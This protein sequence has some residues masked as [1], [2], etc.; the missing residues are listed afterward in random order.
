MRPTGTPH[1]LT[2]PQ[3][4]SWQSWQKPAK[5]KISYQSQLRSLSVVLVKRRYFFFLSTLRLAERKCWLPMLSFPGIANPFLFVSFLSYNLTCHCMGA[6]KICLDRNVGCPPFNSCGPT[7]CCQLE[8]ELSFFWLSSGMALN[9][10]R[11][12]FLCPVGDLS[13][14]GGGVV[15]Y[16]KEYLLFVLAATW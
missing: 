14:G 7:N 12:V 11:I 2:S 5:G 4:A 13:C 10:A 3:T 8:S 6:L 9:P 16:N 15:Q 1:W